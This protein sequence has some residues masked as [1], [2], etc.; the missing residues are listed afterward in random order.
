MKLARTEK[1]MYGSLW[2][3]NRVYKDGKKVMGTI[4]KNP[5]TDKYELIKSNFKKKKYESSEHSKL[6]DAIRRLKK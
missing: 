1:V 5:F 4:L 3:K 2:T 6:K